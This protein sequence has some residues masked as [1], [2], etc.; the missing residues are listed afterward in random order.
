MF[1]KFPTMILPIVLFALG[2]AILI[3]GADIMV[4]GSASLA[5]K[6]KISPLII[7]LTIV[8]FGTSA[9]EL[10][11]NIF[12]ALKGNADIGVGNII[13]SNISNILLILGV[14][15]LITPINVQNST[16]KKEIPLSLLAAIMVF[17]MANDILFDGMSEN[18]LSRTDGLALM[19]LFFIFLAYTFNLKNSKN[20]EEAPPKTYSMGISILFVLLGI[21]ALFWGG[22]LLVDNAVI[23]AKL[24]GL[25]EAFI[26]LTVVAVGTSLPELAT[27]AVAAAKNQS[28]IAIGNV[29]GSNIFNIFWILGLTS[30]IFPL[31]ISG[32]INQDIIVCMGVTVL[33]FL[34]MFVGRKRQLERWQAGMFL[35]LYASYISYLV[36]RG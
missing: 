26:G 14:A 2:L 3:V 16:V 21:G 17:F 33:L 32:Q 7:G 18:V 35:V 15:A 1:S 29:V 4:R 9:P 27:S 23:L 28:D 20:N 31:H 34:C 24:A 5:Y 30:T 12:A 22:Q 13:G 25:S 8:S 10:I 36:Y 6:M 19:G 11:V